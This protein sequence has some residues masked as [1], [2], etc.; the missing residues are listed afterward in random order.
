MLHHTWLRTLLWPRPRCGHWHPRV[1]SASPQLGGAVAGAA[2]GIEHPRGNSRQLVTPKVFAHSR[3]RSRHLVAEIGRNDFGAGPRTPAGIGGGDSF[4]RLEVH[5]LSPGR[6]GLGSPKR[7]ASAL[8]GTGAPLPGGPGA[9]STVQPALSHGRRQ[10][11]N[12]RLRTGVTR[13]G[14]GR[15]HGLPTR[16][17]PNQHRWLTGPELPRRFN[18]LAARGA[19]LRHLVVAGFGRIRTGDQR[20]RSTRWTPRTR[21]EDTHESGSRR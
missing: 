20:R 15:R 17:L 13:T 18:G 2:A 4:P 10:G 14:L 19:R 8:P 9:S 1:R 5:Q 21:C 12:D 11:R 7:S 16:H 3:H 6:G